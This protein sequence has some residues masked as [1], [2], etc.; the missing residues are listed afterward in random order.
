MTWDERLKRWANVEALLKETC[1]SVCEF[2]VVKTLWRKMTD[3]AEANENYRVDLDTWL[4]YPSTLY[5][6][7]LCEHFGKYWGDNEH[8]NSVDRLDAVS[9]RFSS[10]N[11]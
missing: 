6:R 9:C 3:K 5:L 2:H 7:G 1:A 8:A 11:D 4:Y 10:S